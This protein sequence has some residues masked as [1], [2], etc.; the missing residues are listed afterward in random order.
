M[1]MIMLLLTLMTIIIGVWFLMDTH[2]V[3]N[4]TIEMLFNSFVCLHTNRHNYQA[5]VGVRAIRS[6][7]FRPL[8]RLKSIVLLMIARNTASEH[9]V[10]LLLSLC[11]GL[12]FS[13]G[14]LYFFLI[15]RQ[16][17]YFL[18]SSLHLHS[19]YSCNWI[20][21]CN[22]LVD[23][24]PLRSVHTAFYRYCLY[25]HLPSH[26]QHSWWWWRWTE[27][28]KTFHFKLFTIL[29]TLTSFFNYFLPASKSERERQNA[30]N[31]ISTDNSA[32]AFQ[33]LHR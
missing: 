13:F 14:K 31:T 24:F 7:P 19:I 28:L 17:F 23:F 33:W 5:H 25:R 32:K 20:V 4:T 10:L 3:H 12:R 30:R 8:I 22:S 16:F 9:T 2:F 11:L 26:Q 6:Y 18:L 15:F 1:M 21:S 27:S 29:W